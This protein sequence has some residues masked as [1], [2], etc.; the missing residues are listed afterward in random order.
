MN[1][2]LRRKKL[3]QSRH[4][5]SADSTSYTLS[6]GLF[7]ILGLQTMTEAVKYIDSTAVTSITTLEIVFGYQAQVFI[8]GRETDLCSVTGAV[9]TFASI[10][11]ITLEPSK[12]DQYEAK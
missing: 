8:V 11:L 6:A 3:H 10:I 1:V 12:R 7:S 2:S 5:C 9:I 4:A